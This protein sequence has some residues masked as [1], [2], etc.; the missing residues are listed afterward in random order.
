MNAIEREWAEAVLSGF[1]V[2][3]MPQGAG[4]P[5]PLEGV[6][7]PGA[8]Q[9]LVTH[10][11][12]VASIGVRAALAI[13]A[14]SPIWHWKQARTMVDLTPA[15]RSALL[16]ELV[17]DPRFAVRELAVLMKIQASMALFKSTAVRTWSGYGRDA[18]RRQLSVLRAVGGV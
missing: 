9:S 15:E 4:S 3:D 8:I 10:G 7:F 14:T 18:S 6:D 16:T 13:V 2:G 1:L 12:P 17:S 11:N 5:P